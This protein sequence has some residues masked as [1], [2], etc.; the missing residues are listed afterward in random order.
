MSTSPRATCGR[1]RRHGEVGLA[2]LREPGEWFSVGTEKPF[3]RL[4]QEAE[5]DLSPAGRSIGYFTS[6]NPMMHVT[7]PINSNPR[8]TLAG[9]PNTITPI[10]AVPAAPTPAHMA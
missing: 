9:S 10:T 8:T 7:S 6:F 3:S 2:P 1:L 5:S 4:S